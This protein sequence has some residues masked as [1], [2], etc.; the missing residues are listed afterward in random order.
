MNLRT[1]PSTAGEE[2]SSSSRL[3]LLSR[4]PTRKTTSCR[5]RA[6]SVGTLYIVEVGDLG[7]VVGSAAAAVSRAMPES[8]WA[9]RESVP[10]AS[11]DPAGAESFRRGSIG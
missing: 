10:L 2:I 8:S 7:A 9:A 6:V 3:I 11:L 1:F 4:A 5:R